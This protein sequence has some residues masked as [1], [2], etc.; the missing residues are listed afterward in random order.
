MEERRNTNFRK[1]TENSMHVR[2][3]IANSLVKADHPFLHQ[4]FRIGSDKKVGM[5][6]G[7]NKV[8]IFLY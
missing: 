2:L 1:S 6:S 4:V 5:S 8:S 3:E 7:F